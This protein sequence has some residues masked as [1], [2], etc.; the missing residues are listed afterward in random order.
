M[1]LAVEVQSL[2]QWTSRDVSIKLLKVTFHLQLYQNI[3]NVPRV[4]WHSLEPISQSI[5]CLPL[6]YPML[7]LHSAPQVVTT[8]FSIS[9]SLFA[10]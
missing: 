1:C 4:V 7:P 10:F 6:P 5:V 3:G 2:T 9:V 8:L